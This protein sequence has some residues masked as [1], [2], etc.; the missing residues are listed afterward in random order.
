MFYAEVSL[1]HLLGIFASGFCIF[2]HR[3]PTKCSLSKKCPFCLKL[4]LVMFINKDFAK[5]K[6]I[7]IFW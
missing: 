5:H 2:I 6:H 4:Y 1:L 7:L 3:N